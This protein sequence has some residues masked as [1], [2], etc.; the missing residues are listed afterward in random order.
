MLKLF[1]FEHFFCFHSLAIT[2]ADIAR[3]VGPDEVASMK[4]PVGSSGTFGL[5][6][7]DFFAWPIFHSIA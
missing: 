4:L 1:Q 3:V 2:V 6:V 5:V 7:Q